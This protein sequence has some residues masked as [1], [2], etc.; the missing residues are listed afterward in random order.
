MSSNEKPKVMYQRKRLRYAIEQKFQN[1]V[2]EK[3]PQ[4]CH[5]SKTQM[6]YLEGRRF[7]AAIGCLPIGAE[8]EHKT[9][10]SVAQK[11]LTDWN[12]LHIGC[13]K[14]ANKNLLCL[15]TYRSINACQIPFIPENNQYPFFDKITIKLQIITNKTDYT[16]PA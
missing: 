4:V 11:P 6:M 12:H 10:H 5:Q 7:Q 9:T 8:M 2:L 13:V 14:L 16:V 1:D 15:P 3:A